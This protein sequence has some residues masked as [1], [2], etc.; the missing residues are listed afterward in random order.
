[1]NHPPTSETTSL[2]QDTVIILKNVPPVNQQAS[3]EMTP[4]NRNTVNNHK[5]DSTTP[6]WIH[7]TKIA[8]RSKKHTNLAK[9]PEDLFGPSSRASPTGNGKRKWG[10]GTQ[11][12]KCEKTKRTKITPTN[13]NSIKNTS[14]KSY[15]ICGNTIK[16]VENI[17]LK[18]V[19]IH[20][21]KFNNMEIKND[22]TDKS[23]HL[24]REVAEQPA[25]VL[26]DL[27]TSTSPS[28]H[29]KSC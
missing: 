9:N 14:I 21:K 8:S 23:D 19:E 10:V 29:Q 16:A 20:E 11:Q 28:K 27:M 24:K 7:D 13:Q 6:T 22:T 17:N 12:A 4:P 26:V 25:N 1:M 15:F 18:N 2:N 3:P 5:K